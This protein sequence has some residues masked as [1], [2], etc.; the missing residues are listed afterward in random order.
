MSA[1]CTIGKPS[2]ASFQRCLRLLCEGEGDTRMLW[3]GW[4]KNNFHRCHLNLF[5]LIILFF[6]LLFPET[7]NLTWLK[8]NADVPTTP[9]PVEKSSRRS[10]R[11]RTPLV[12]KWV[13]WNHVINKHKVQCISYLQI[14][15]YW[16]MRL[17]FE[18]PVNELLNFFCG[19]HCSCCQCSRHHKS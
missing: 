12:K 14:W 18:K 17:R 5:C 15:I 3:F 13:C 7:F 16:N 4:Q 1:L 6:S 19:M 2:E 11:V 10:S 9:A 8:V